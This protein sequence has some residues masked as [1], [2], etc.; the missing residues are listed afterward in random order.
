MPHRNDDTHLRPVAENDLPVFDLLYCG[1]PQAASAYGWF[2]WSDRH[3]PGL[4]QL[5]S[6]ADPAD[7]RSH[8]VDGPAHGLPMLTCLLDVVSRMA[9]TQDDSTAG[10]LPL[11]TGR[12]GDGRLWQCKR[13]T[14]N[15]WPGSGR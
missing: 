5:A 9:R 7:Q 4:G 15:C 1:G 3:P 8:L 11:R 10:P 2:G 12:H 14:M 13:A 6:R